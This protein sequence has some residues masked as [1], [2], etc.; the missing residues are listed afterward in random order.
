MVKFNKKAMIIEIILTIIVLL[1]TMALIALIIL[2]TIKKPKLYEDFYVPDIKIEGLESFDFIDDKITPDYPYDNLGLTGKLILDCVSGSCV[3]EKFI[4][5][6]YQ[7]CSDGSCGVSY[8][9]WTNYITKIDD[10]CTQQCNDYGIE[11]CNCPSGYREKGTCRRRSDD[12][13][14]EGKICNISNAI[15]FWKGKKYKAKNATNYTYLKNAFLKDEECPNKKSKYCGI[16]DDDGNK[17][18][19]NSKYKCPINYISENYT[20]ISYSVMIGDKTFYYGNDNTLNNRKIIAGLLA[21]T[22]LYLNEDLNKTDIIDTYNIS[23]FLEDNKNL[24]KNIN[25]G[26]D[27]YEEKDIDKKGNSYLRIYYNEIDL[28][29]LRN[30]KEKSL[31]NHRM[32]SKALNKINKNMKVFSILGLIVYGI[33][34]LGFIYIIYQQ[35]SFLKDGFNQGEKQFYIGFIVL[36]LILIIVHMVFVCININKIKKAEDIDPKANFKFFKLHNIIFIVLCLVLFVFLILYMIFVPVEIKETVEN[37]DIKV[38]YQEK[39]NN[40]TTDNIPKENENKTTIEDI[41]KN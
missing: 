32:N 14:A 5:T 4:E 15:Y 34:L 21:D 24:Y 20:D 23:E 10:K 3:Q 41:N 12:R 40:S 27:P 18:C 35:C 19:I 26:Y 30:M 13:Y 22:D 38:A 28:T 25:L 29:N 37:K 1:F 17:L 39:I 11:E 6:E 7:K 8:E 33:I 2:L 31:M 9:K 16:I 36:I